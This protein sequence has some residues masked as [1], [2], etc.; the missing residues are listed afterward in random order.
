MDHQGLRLPL[1]TRSN[2]SL[3]KSSQADSS[4]TQK[5][6]KLPKATTRDSKFRK[7]P[8]GGRSGKIGGS[9]VR[10]PGITGSKPLVPAG[11]RKSGGHDGNK[12]KRDTDGDKWNI[13]PDGGS[14]GR[15]GRHF[16]VANVGNGGK[17][18][19]R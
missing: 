18:F 15:E 6:Q 1:Q 8:L 19:L 3:F 2:L 9:K 5:T 10:I 17:I 7:S 11:E 4:K 14:A 12:A 16:T 13:T